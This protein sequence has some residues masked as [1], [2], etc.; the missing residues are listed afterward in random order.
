[1]GAWGCLWA[2]Q[3]WLNEAFL[4]HTTWEGDVI[5]LQP[6]RQHKALFTE[7]RKQNKYI[8]PK[9]PTMRL[10]HGSA[11]EAAS[12]LHLAGFAGPFL[13]LGVRLA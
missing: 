3:A 5:P 9:D 11:R 13:G 2:A 7:L 10:F 8:L 1:M 12:S 6:H 4:F